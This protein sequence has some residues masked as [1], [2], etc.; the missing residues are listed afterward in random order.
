MT[1]NGNRARARTSNGVCADSSIDRRARM[2]SIRLVLADIDRAYEGDV[3]TVLRSEA[4]EVIKQ[5]V[6][7]TLKQRHQERRARYEQQ[8]EVLT[9]SRRARV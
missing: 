9:I 3:E 7:N 5:E 2:Q 4:P 6:L 8:L 1:T